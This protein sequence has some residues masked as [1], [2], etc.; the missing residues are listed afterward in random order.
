MLGHEKPHCKDC[1]FF[2][3]CAE[4]QKEIDLVCHDYCY[5]YII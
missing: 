3:E 1:I 4:E 2:K 5:D